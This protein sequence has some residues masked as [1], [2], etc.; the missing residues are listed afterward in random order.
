MKKILLICLCLSCS[1]SFMAQ[2]RISGKITDNT[3]EGLIGV[4]VVQKGTGN[5]E[6]TDV[7]GMF[8]INLLPNASDAI[9]VSM[10]GYKKV[11]IDTKNKTV[12]NVTLHDDNMNL[13][14]VVVVGYGTQKKAS[15]TGA[16]SNVGNKEL[17]EVPVASVTNALTGRVPGLVTRQESGRPGGDEATM[18]IR[19]LATFSA[20]SDPLVLVDGVE[21]SF[22]QINQDDIESISVLKDASATAVYGVR[23]ANGV[24]LVTT[25]R[26]QERERAKINFSAELGMTQFNR[27]TKTLGAADV[28]RFQREGS[29]N[30]GLDVSNTANTKNF[31]VSEYD[32]YLYDSQ[33]SPFTHPDNDF[34][35]I[36]TKNGYTQKYN[37]NASGGTKKLKYFVSFSHYHQTGMFQTDVN[38]IRKHPT[39]K[40]LIEL[41]PEV[42]AALK[43]PDY[44]PEYYFN[45]TTARSN[46]DISLT[47][48]LS[49][50]I[51]LSYIFR[52]QNRPA[53]Y[54]GLD[55]NAENMRLFGQ[56]YRNSPQAFPI[57]NPNGSMAANE[58]VWRQNPLVTMAY[59][60]FRSDY[61]N[62]LET[63]ISFN[64]NLRK[65]LTGLSIDGRF[66]FDS[67]WSNWRGMQWRP[68]IYS[69]NAVSDTYKQGL[70]G[71]TRGTGSNRV[72]ATYQT[73]GELALRYKNIFARKHSVSGV[74]L[75]SIQSIS[76]PNG[77]TEY[78][79]VPH[80]YQNLVG[81]VNYDYSGRYLVEFNGGYNGS[82]RFAEGDR[83]AFF[84]SGS[85]GWIPTSEPFFPE[86]DILNFLKIRGSV[87]KVGNDNLGGSFDY[88]YVGAYG[89]ETFPINGSSQNPSGYAFGESTGTAKTQGLIELTMA[90]LVTWE[91]ATK[92]NVGIET[93][94]FDSN[95]SFN[96]D[97]FK[98]RR[99]NILTYPERYVLAAGAVGLP[100]YNL[101]IVENKGLEMELGWN[102]TIRDVSYYIKGIYGFN[103]NKI[104]EKSEAEKP[105]SYMYEAGLPINQ[106]MGYQFDGFF[107]SYEEIA[108]SPQQFGLTNLQPGD[109]KYKD[110][111]GDGIIDENDQTAIGYSTIPEITASVQA[112]IS[113]KGFDVSVM[114]QGA[115]RYS[116]HLTQDVGWDNFFGNYFEEH[117]GR[118]TPETASTATYPR[119]GKGAAEDTNNY[120]LSDFWLKD[121]EYIRLKNIMI[122]YTFNKKQLKKTPLSSL[123]I[124]ANGFNVYTWDKVKKMDPEVGT[125]TTSARGYIYP[126]QRQYNIGVNVSF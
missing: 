11:E 109:M 49:I 101:G 39:I 40:K 125:S 64:Y 82:N 7:N 45:R 90:N 94:W 27:I 93:L 124:F 52:K 112:G 119:F 29:A 8:T 110:I 73:Y 57:V 24:I 10:I 13:D 66:S 1:L 83:Y 2:R 69:Y 81:R 9:E 77:N 70:A 20:S 100:P 22:S 68:Y 67:N 99:V 48:D 76:Q 85:L 47:D 98:E 59:T 60:G 42:D 34:V 89:T 19:G 75:G 126:Q 108:A 117:I 31:G 38:E 41:S 79:Y 50:G 3:G 5:G 53:T 103:R 16:I 61:K 30:D 35:D 43:N 17:G 37:L 115:T 107:S 118:W 14:E 4:T 78:V 18:F 56:F 87:G 122:S 36:F 96:M 62:A 26:G 72:A 88:Y 46:L 120:Y 65:V 106:F 44:N 32:I 116:V 23:G 91:T 74:L 28:A 97:L 33:E 92:Y 55:S 114:F 121:G 6:I 111:N 15:I 95:L 113:Y 102:Q 54:D 58:N 12:V 80:V 86:N 104:I 25:R 51:D 105:Y 63:A 71:V 123:K 21:R 84:P